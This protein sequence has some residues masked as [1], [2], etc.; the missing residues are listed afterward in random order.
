VIFAKGRNI[1][2]GMVKLYYDG[3]HQ[4]FSDLFIGEEY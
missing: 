3:G 1:K 2:T 4:K